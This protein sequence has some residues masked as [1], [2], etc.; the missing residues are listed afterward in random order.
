[1][2]GIDSFLPRS[3]YQDQNYKGFKLSSLCSQNIAM[4]GQMWLPQ[5][6][7]FSLHLSFLYPCNHQTLQ[8]ELDQCRKARSL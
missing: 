1:M 6:N 5:G 8:S 2:W 4:K 3:P 7:I